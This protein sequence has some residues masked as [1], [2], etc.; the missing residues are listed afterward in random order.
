MAMVTLTDEELVLLDGR[1]S[2]KV[3]AE[4][5][6]AKARLTAAQTMSGVSPTVAGFV[7]DA[8]TLAQKDLKLSFER[9]GLRRCRICDKCAGYHVYK[10]GRQ[11]GRENLDKPLYLQGVE[12]KESF[13]RMRGYATLG[14]CADCWTQV[15]PLVA[16]AVKDLAAEVHPQIAPGHPWKRYQRVKCNSCKWQGHEGQLAPAPALMGGFYPGKCPQ[17]GNQNPFFGQSI[18]ERVSDEYVVLRV[19]KEAKDAMATN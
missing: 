6:A 9:C 5:A 19:K 4:V 11:K 3:Q 17:C 1:C 14:C 8:V 7:A 10:S 18:I 16:E 2:E 15:Q 13:M 12:L